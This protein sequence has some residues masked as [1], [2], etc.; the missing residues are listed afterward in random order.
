MTA[1]SRR[2]QYLRNAERTPEA[3][4]KMYPKLSKKK[5]THTHKRKEK[6]IQCQ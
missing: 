4:K 2:A 1:M 6:E 5:H 3:K